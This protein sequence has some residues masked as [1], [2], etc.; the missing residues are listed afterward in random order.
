MMLSVSLF[1]VKPSSGRE[2]VKEFLEL[3]R[4]NKFLTIQQQEK[5]ENQQR[6]C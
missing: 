6:T 3:V 1:K 2:F 4:K 5:F